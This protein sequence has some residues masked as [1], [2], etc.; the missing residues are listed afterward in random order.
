MGYLCLPAANKYILTGKV[1]KT[2]PMNIKFHVHSC[3]SWRLLETPVCLDT[4]W[5]I[6]RRACEKELLSGHHQ[7]CCCLLTLAVPISLTTAGSCHNIL[8]FHKKDSVPNT[9]EFCLKSTE[10][11]TTKGQVTP[12]KTIAGNVF[13]STIPGSHS[14]ISI[15]N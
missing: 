2:S 3:H 12:G 15:I 11:R 4:F 9:H 8:C 6:C 5:Y 13:L 7:S 14:I 10:K 1:T